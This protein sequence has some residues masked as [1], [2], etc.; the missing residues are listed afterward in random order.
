M[1]K[2]KGK[3]IE[4]DPMFGGMVRGAQAHHQRELERVERERQERQ[5]E[6]D[7]K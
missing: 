7:R 4:D 2:N 6:Q 5:Q 3:D 1:G